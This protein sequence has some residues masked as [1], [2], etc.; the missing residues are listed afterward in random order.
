[1]IRQEQARWQEE[2]GQ[3]RII[4]SPS[5]PTSDFT[6]AAIG[7]TEDRPDRAASVEAFLTTLN[8]YNPSM[9]PVK[10]DA[11]R[12][13]SNSIQPMAE[14]A[15]LTQTPGTWPSWGDETLDR[16]LQELVDTMAER[17]GVDR[18]KCVK[19]SGT[20]A[21]VLMI[22]WNYPPLND[23]DVGNYGTTLDLFNYCIR[24]ALM[25]LGLA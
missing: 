20:L 22:N 11:V 21:A 8:L 10:L 19:P 5:T 24:K 1:M 13:I 16:H 3:W 4:T 6:S 14:S 18:A 25:K 23:T 17:F 2:G 9:T 15:T 12:R 7:S